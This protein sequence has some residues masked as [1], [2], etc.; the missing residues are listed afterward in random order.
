MT[1]T[2]GKDGTL[3]LPPEVLETLGTHQ[4][5]LRLE[6]KTVTLEPRKKRISELET[7]E[8]RLTAF[9]TWAAR[10]VQHSAATLPEDWVTIKDSI[11]LPLLAT[12]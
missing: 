8:E 5:E 12:V 1:I 9:D 7:V 11:S 3:K 6:G 4:V 2:I 10:A